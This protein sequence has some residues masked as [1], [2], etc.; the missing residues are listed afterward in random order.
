M[1]FGLQV[2]RGN[3]GGTVSKKRKRLLVFETMDQATVLSPAN[4][5]MKIVYII[6]VHR[7]KISWR[8]ADN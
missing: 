1:L 8:F 4:V 7:L 2:G 6:L 3:L 5:K